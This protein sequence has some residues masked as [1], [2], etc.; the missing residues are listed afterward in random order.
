[1]LEAQHR[2]KDSL[3]IEFRARRSWKEVEFSNGLFS[4]TFFYANDFSLRAV[5]FFPDQETFAAQ[6]PMG[7]FTE[8]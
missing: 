3:F 8:T 2:N 5:K 7:Q 4:K 1:M 6:Q